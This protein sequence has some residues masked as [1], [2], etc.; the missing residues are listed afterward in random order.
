MFITCQLEQ[1]AKKFRKNNI[2]VD[3]VSFGEVTHSNPHQ[4]VSYNWQESNNEKLQGFIGAVDKESSSHLVCIPS[5]AGSLADSIISSAVV[6]GESGF[7]SVIVGV[8]IELV[9]GCQ[10]FVAAA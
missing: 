1:L 2:S 9:Q 8:G 7:A 3:I 6:S 4:L 5:G 10:C